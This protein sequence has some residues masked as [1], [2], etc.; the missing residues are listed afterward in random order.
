MASKTTKKM[1]RI[2]ASL[3]ALIGLLFTMLYVFVLESPDDHGAA[4]IGI[5]FLLVSFALSRY[6]GKRVIDEREVRVAAKANKMALG[7]VLL[8]TVLIAMQA[9]VDPGFISLRFAAGVAFAIAISV[10][11]ASYQLLKMLPN[12][13]QDKWESG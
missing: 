8:Y 7:A 9:K 12:A 13:E 4:Y 11:I 5:S 3:G 2:I 10:S 6:V 1:I